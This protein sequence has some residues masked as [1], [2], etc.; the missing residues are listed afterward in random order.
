[1]EGLSFGNITSSGW[2]KFEGP[3][4]SVG[5]FEVGSASRDF[6]D[7]I[8]HAVD[9][10][11]TEALFNDKIAGQGDSLSGNFSISSFID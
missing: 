2:V 1:V 3:E 11:F 7:K 6:V 9:A 10:K 8:F 5:S 4:E